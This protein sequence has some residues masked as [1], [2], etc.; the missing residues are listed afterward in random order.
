M[1]QNPAIVVLA[2]QAVPAPAG[3]AVGEQPSHVASALRDTVAHAMQTRWR[4]VIVTT[5]AW[6]PLV[7]RWVATR[8]LVTLSDE[9]LGRGQGYAL[10]VGV[11]AHVDAA[12]WLMLPGDRSQV[13]P[14]TLLAVGDALKD[15]PIAYAQVQGRRGYPLGF[16]AELVS[17]L[18]AL[19]GDDGAQRLLGRYPAWGVTVDDP[20]VLEGTVR[21]TESAGERAAGA[22]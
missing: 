13:R 19:Q 6:V 10:A 20:G 15:H 1:E 7:S 8:D 22:A 5:P 12:G 9:E 16:A 17:D 11:A 3:T 18:I 21:G 14:Q 4:V 2:T